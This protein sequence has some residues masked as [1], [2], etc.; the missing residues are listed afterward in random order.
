MGGKL[1]GC[2]QK[3]DNSLTPTTV[4][5]HFFPRVFFFVFAMYKL[6]QSP[7][8]DHLNTWNRLHNPLPMHF[9]FSFVYTES[10]SIMRRLSLVPRKGR[11]YI[12]I[13]PLVDESLATL[14]STVNF[15]ISDFVSRK[16]MKVADCRLLCT[17]KIKLWSVPKSLFWTFSSVPRFEY[18]PRLAS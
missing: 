3:I 13:Q 4:S 10:H 18:V 5:P 11:V 8:S 7:P 17:D 14:K 12:E 1:V 15:C 9:S 16:K 6:S 2:R